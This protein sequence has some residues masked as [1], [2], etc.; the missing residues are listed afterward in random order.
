METNWLRLS[1]AQSWRFARYGAAT[2]AK[3]EP[4][5]F[6]TRTPS[7]AIRRGAVDHTDE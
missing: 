2:L 5:F 3:G 1:F 6:I 7:V 4:F